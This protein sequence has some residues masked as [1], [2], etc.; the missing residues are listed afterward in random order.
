MRRAMLWAVVSAAG[1]V[2]ELAQDYDAAAE[3]LSRRCGC[4]ETIK[5]CRRCGVAL[6][7][8]EATFCMPK[9]LTE[10]QEAHA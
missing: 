7:F 5:V 6:V 4:A 1:D 8:A 9:A 2:L 10:R 3:A